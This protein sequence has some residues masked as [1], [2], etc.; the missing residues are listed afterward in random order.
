M[1]L[2]AQCV[3][4]LHTFIYLRIVIGV[5]SPENKIFLVFEVFCYLR[6]RL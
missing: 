2:M 3:Y 4:D 5:Y 6:M 1:V